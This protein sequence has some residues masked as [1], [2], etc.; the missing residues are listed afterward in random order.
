MQGSTV[1]WREGVFRKGAP[2]RCTTVLQRRGG[3]CWGREGAVR[4][5]KKRYCRAEVEG[6]V[7]GEG[8]E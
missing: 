2:Q 4:S 6:E 8:L 1:E 5:C 3:W 7:L